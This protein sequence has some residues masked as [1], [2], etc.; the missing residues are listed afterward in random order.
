M[1]ALLSPHSGTTMADDAL[2]SRESSDEAEL[3]DDDGAPGE[4]DLEAE[5]IT[6]EATANQDDAACQ[7]MEYVQAH[8]KN[9]AS[10]LDDRRAVGRQ[11]PSTVIL[12]LNVKCRLEVLT[13]WKH[14]VLKLVFFI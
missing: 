12:T 10:V 2:S 6:H 9:A 11:H 1:E 4:V 14:V 5:P 3:S 8:R 7:F 13:R